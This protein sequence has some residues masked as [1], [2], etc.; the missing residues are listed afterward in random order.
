[1]G[2]YLVPVAACSEQHILFFCVLDAGN[3]GFAVMSRAIIRV[4]PNPGAGWLRY[5]LV[6][7][8]TQLAV[9]RVAVATLLCF[10]C[11][12]PSKDKCSS[13]TPAV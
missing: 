4:D 12:V 1:M 6:G 9:V 13:W 8:V 10:R 2:M 5:D 3:V 7:L 11:T